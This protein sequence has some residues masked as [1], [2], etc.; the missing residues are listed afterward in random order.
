MEYVAILARVPLL[1]NHITLNETPTQA[2]PQRPIQ[3]PR[4]ELQD[5]PHSPVPKPQ[6]SK[7]RREPSISRHTARGHSS[8][9]K[10]RTKI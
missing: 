8:R 2:G 5:L 4:S 10:H 1:N 7:E 3:E 6:L 9:W